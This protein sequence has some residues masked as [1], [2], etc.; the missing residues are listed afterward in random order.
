M[1][2]MIYS[3]VQLKCLHLKRLIIIFQKSY[4]FYKNISWISYVFVKESA[5]IHFI[6]C[7]LSKQFRVPANICISHFIQ[8]V[9][10]VASC[11][12]SSNTKKEKIKTVLCKNSIAFFHLR[13]NIWLSVS[14]L[15]IY[16]ILI[17]HTVLVPYILEP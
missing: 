8:K 15:I 4:V 9:Q 3:I 14:V 6:A 11:K 10:R 17:W 1:I 5:S 13:F 12:T 16:S 2:D 7:Y